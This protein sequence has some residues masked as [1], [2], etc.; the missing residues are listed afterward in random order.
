MN[1]TDSRELFTGT[2]TER[3]A[4]RQIAEAEQLSAVLRSARPSIDRA[5][6]NLER[7][8]PLFYGKGDNPC[9]F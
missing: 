1:P 9:F 8:S 4:A 3:E 7:E 2:D 6:G 5:T